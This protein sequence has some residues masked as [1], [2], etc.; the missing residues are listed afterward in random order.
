[1]IYQDTGSYLEAEK[2]LLKAG[3]GYEDLGIVRGLYYINNNLGQIYEELSRYDEAL[4]HYR[5]AL[6]IQQE[7]GNPSQIGLVL[8]NMGSVYRKIGQQDK[9]LT[10]FSDA[11]GYIRSSDQQFLLAI[12]LL[13]IAEIYFEQGDLMTAI[14]RGE[15]SLDTARMVGADEVI[16]SSSLFL[17]TVY[18]ITGRHEEALVH[19]K[20]YSEKQEKLM[21]ENLLNRLQELT[22]QRQLDEKEKTI[23]ELNE[24][25]TIQS[26][27]RNFLI[28]I[29]A[30][31]IG[32]AGIIFFL[33]RSKRRAAEMA[34]EKNKELVKSEAA[35]KSSNDTKNKLLSIVAHDLRNPISVMMSGLQLLLDPQVSSRE[36]SRERLLNNLK[37]TTMQVYSL[38]ENLLYW[39]KTQKDEII[40][41]PRPITL[42]DAV[43]E[44][45]RLVEL[46]AEQK[47]IDIEKKL[48]RDLAVLADETMFHTI[49]RNFLTNS[50]KFTRKG[51][52]I[53][54]RGEAENGMIALS[55]EDTGV[56]M[57]D[58]VISRI[59][60]RN[61]TESSRGTGS[62]KG[63]GLGLILCKD[64]IE[65]NRGMLRVESVP[66]KGSTVTALF[67]SA[68]QSGSDNSPYPTIEGTT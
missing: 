63:S 33:Y 47:E 43:E 50:I 59:L 13:S 41:E 29:S 21:N 26:L 54:I 37:T 52:T 53:T 57:D 30:S 9:A 27:V 10:H 48:D 16:K 46:Q 56:G 39:V 15:E 45:I 4:R 11:E 42:V 68:V 34:I 58:Q 8:Y 62:E 44:D 2:N 12:N 64:L 31:I 60:N 25:N 5:K 17:S 20:V 14:E 19:F 3:D 23:R 7:F 66:G 18:E 1:M 22:L 38:L 51:G 61:R 55:V 24:K 6:E 67:P 32:F 49:V 28:I 65:R 35:L 36:E 40:A